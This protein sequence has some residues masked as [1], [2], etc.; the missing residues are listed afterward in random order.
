MEELRAEMALG[1]TEAELLDRLKGPR[2]QPMTDPLRERPGAM[3][4]IGKRGNAPQAPPPPLPAAAA[5]APA[6]SSCAAPAAPA[7]PGRAVTK[8]ES[9]EGGTAWHGEQTQTA[10]GQ[11]QVRLR[12][13]Q[14]AITEPSVGLYVP[15]GH[16]M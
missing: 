14:L 8:T 16:W 13:A 3:G 2:P 1:A 9:A 4:P 6:E 10:P 7:P 12:A 15:G 5:A 11:G